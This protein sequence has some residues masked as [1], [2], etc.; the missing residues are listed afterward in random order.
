MNRRSRLSILLVAAFA[1]GVAACGEGKRYDQAV[2]VLIDVSGTYADQLAEVVRIV[3]SEVLPSMEP[4]DTLLVLRIDAESYEKDNVEVLVTLDARPSR[5]NAEKLG[6]A[7]RLDELAKREGAARHTDIPGA[8]MLGGEYLRELIAGSRVMLI[9][10]D[11][12]EDLAPG[13]RR[14][15][16]TDE[17]AGTHVLAINVKRLHE[18]NIDPDG[19]RSRLASWEKRVLTSGGLGWRNLMDPTMLGDVLSEIREGA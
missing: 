5:A 13:T 14:T 12:E 19:F 18:D 1:F 4:G 11:L 9:F 7:Q 15:L 16:R 6:I 3:K 2:C 8:M 17:F 10:S